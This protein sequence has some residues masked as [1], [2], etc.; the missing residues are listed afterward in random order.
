MTSVLKDP[1]KLISGLGP[2]KTAIVHNED[3]AEKAI[4]LAEKEGLR[5]PARSNAGLPEGVWRLTFLPESPFVNLTNDEHL[6]KAIADLRT[7]DSREDIDQ[8]DPMPVIDE[9]LRRLSEC[10]KAMTTCTVLSWHK[11]DFDETKWPAMAWALDE[12]VKN[13]QG[14][15]NL[16]NFAYKIAYDKANASQSAD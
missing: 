7:S 6:L 12:V 14:A 9:L 13:L 5:C 11:D 15:R 10:C 3:Q 1:I 2:M 16:S 8:D 4:R